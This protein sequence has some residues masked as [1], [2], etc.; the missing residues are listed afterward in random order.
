MET[1]K[2]EYIEENDRLNQLSMN[3]WFMR[4]MLA[5]AWCSP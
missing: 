1:E 3:I 5:I 2:K 4:E